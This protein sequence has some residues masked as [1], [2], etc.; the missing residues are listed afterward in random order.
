[1]MR[2]RWLLLTAVLCA[3]VS[4]GG[5]GAGFLGVKPVLEIVVG[6]PLLD[7]AGERLLKAD[8]TLAERDLAYFAHQFNSIAPA[9]L[10]VPQ[11]WIARLPTGEF[12]AVMWIMVG[13][14]GLTLIGP[15][16][17]SGASRST[18]SSASR[19]RSSWPTGPPT[20]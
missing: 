16:P 17:T 20:R 2:Y 14:A 12:T 3:L 4:A 5:L 15:S 8:G 6:E 9:A 1:M 7:D 10:M 11:Q 19:S 13:L 18:T